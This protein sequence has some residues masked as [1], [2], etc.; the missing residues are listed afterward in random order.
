MVGPTVDR[1]ITPWYQWVRC[2]RVHATFKAIFGK[3]REEV[4]PVALGLATMPCFSPISSPLPLISKKTGW[5]KPAYGSQ[6]EIGPSLRYLWVTTTVFPKPFF[7]Y[8]SHISHSLLTYCAL[9]PLSLSLSSF[10]YSMFCIQSTKEER[11]CHDNRFPC[12]HCHPQSYIR[13]VSHIQ[14]THTES[15]ILFDVFQVLHKKC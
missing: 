8:T 10:H 3:R 15:L 7:L 14:K 6:W 12:F 13:M 2:W 4:E 5:G 9:S 1:V 11:M